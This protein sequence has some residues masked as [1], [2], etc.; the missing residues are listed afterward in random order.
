M[1][2][3]AHPDFCT[4]HDCFRDGG[5]AHHRDYSRRGLV[6]RYGDCEAGPYGD[7]GEGFTVHVSWHVI[8][9]KLLFHRSEE[10][11]LTAGVYVLDGDTGQKVRI[12]TSI[13]DLRK[14]AE[15]LNDEADAL[16][17]WRIGE[18]ARRAEGGD[19]Q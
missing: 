1:S 8:D 9:D 19:G 17:S 7:D 6:H 12:R 13:G 2:G 3:A 4:K 5:G 16:E 15:Y 11:S 10:W 18:I 14:I